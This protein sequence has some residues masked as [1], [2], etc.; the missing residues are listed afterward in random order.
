MPDRTRFLADAMLARLARWLRVLGF[1]TAYEPLLPDPELVR[2]AVREQRM[3]L[4]RDRRLLRD[5]RPALAFEVRADRPIEQLRT[6]VTSLELPAPSELFTRCLVCNSPLSAPL[7]PTEWPAVVPPGARATAS[8]VRRCP[9]CGR[10]YWEGSHVRRM[11]G[12]LQR[13]LPE[14]L[15]SGNPGRGREAPSQ[16][17]AADASRA[18]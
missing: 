9:G 10:T 16:R 18:D 5:L 17:W 3:L 7:G 1:D 15:C 6:V 4:T 14:W 2:L 12:V 8:P 11:R 13:A